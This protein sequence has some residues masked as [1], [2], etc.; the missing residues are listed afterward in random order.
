MATNE[1]LENR[2]GEITLALNEKGIKANVLV[3]NEGLGKKKQQLYITVSDI[4]QVR[5]IGQDSGKKNCAVITDTLLDI[6]GYG[7]I[8]M[9]PPKDGVLYVT[10]T[11]LRDGEVGKGKDY[12]ITPGAK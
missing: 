8:S 4:D 3:K 11:P 1:N 10:Y 9:D 7:T 12:I 2:V 5:D 6:I